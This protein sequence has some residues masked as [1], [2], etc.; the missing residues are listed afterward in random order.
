[1]ALKH[2][3]NSPSFSPMRLAA[4]DP[5]AQ[6]RLE[7]FRLDGV[8]EEDTSEPQLPAESQRRSR[9]ELRRLRGSSSP[10][11]APNLANAPLAPSPLGRN[12]RRGLQSRDASMLPKLSLPPS[13]HPSN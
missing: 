2:I 9:I 3:R 11:R 6:V 7:E 8:D 4:A 13:L 5:D 10:R 12:A 1:M